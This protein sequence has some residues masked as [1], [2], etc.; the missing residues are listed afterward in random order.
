MSDEQNAGDSSH[1]RRSQTRFLAGFCL[2]C[3]VISLCCVFLLLL[4]VF[5]V[6]KIP[7]GIGQLTI[8]RFIVIVYQHSVLPLIIF[9]AD[10]FKSL[11]PW[12]FIA[13][14]LI[15]L[16]LWNRNLLKELLSSIG[17]VEFPGFKIEG[18]TTDA[19]EVLHKEL[20]DAQKGVERVNKE[21]EEA[22]T[23]AHTYAVQLRDK[24]EISQFVG[25]LASDIA[26]TFESSC[27]GDYRLTVYIPDLVFSDRLYQFTE[28]YDKSGA[29]ISDDRAGRAFS[30]RY[31][32][33]GRVWRSGVPEMEGDL[34]SSEDRN[35]MEQ[36]GESPH[37]PDHLVR[38]IARRWGMTLEEVARHARYKSYGALRVET[39]TK[40]IGIV[41]FDSKQRDAF[42]QSSKMIP[43]I[44]TL[45]RNSKL[46]ERMAEINREVAAWSGRI[47]IYRNS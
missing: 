37:D 32:I 36:L 26:N 16:Y 18:R 4:V 29:R 11:F 30:I 6:F 27:P 42:G 9:L 2:S 47:Q 24:H 20:S 40:P 3:V 21:I 12:P 38:F 23:T 34:I 28:Y 43:A 33:I 10:L 13:L 17:T 39:A 5:V 31:G 22:Y 7:L 35:Q 19:S 14:I 15:A 46:L 45:I 41:Y 25:K 44:G 8:G 1:A